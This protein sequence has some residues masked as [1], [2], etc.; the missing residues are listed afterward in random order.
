M[1]G[2]DGLTPA[3][4]KEVDAAINVARPDQ[5]ARRSA[6]TARP[7]RRCDRNGDKLN[8]APIQHIGKL[9]VLWRPMEEVEAEAR[10]DTDPAR[11]SSRS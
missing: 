6:T 11:G 9:L 5:G 2:G 1:I 4:M 7:A 3:V 10:P 8:A